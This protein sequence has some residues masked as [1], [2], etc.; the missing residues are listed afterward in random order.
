LAVTTTLKI[1]FGKLF[2]EPYQK[3]RDNT[4]VTKAKRVALKLTMTAYLILM[5]GVGIFTVAKI[6]S[7]R[8]EA[9]KLKE[10]IRTEKPITVD[11]KPI[12]DAIWFL[13]LSL[14]LSGGLFFLVADEE[15]KKIRTHRKAEKFRAEQERLAQELDDAQVQ[16][17]DKQRALK[18]AEVKAKLAADHYRERHLLALAQ[19]LKRLP[20]PRPYVDRTEE[21]LANCN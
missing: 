13:A 21:I 16:L 19:A 18:E 10:S 5:G 1:A 7:A 8:S 14:V 12:D 4:S 3:L 9:I 11:P 2:W 17:A 20:Q 15:W 6:S